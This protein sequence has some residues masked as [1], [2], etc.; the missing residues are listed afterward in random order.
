MSLSQMQAI[1][2]ATTESIRSKLRAQYGVK[3]IDNPLLSLSVD[4]YRLAIVA[5]Y[6]LSS[7]FTFLPVLL[8]QLPSKHYIQYFWDHISIY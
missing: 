3:E 7:T 6:I 5:V 2:S 1:K 4:M 8:D